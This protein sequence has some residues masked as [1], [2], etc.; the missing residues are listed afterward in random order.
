MS[1]IV[2]PQDAL[3]STLRASLKTLDE[4]IEAARNAGSEISTRKLV[5]R[6][7]LAA[8]ITEIEVT[9]GEPESVGSHCGGADFTARRS[10]LLRRLLGHPLGAVESDPLA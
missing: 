5:F 3:L 6:A 4:A 8:Y 2:R 10:G 9:D 7:S 1:T